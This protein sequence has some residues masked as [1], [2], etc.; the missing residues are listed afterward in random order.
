[1][2]SIA[3]IA[4]IAKQNFYSTF[5]DIFLDDLLLVFIVKLLPLLPILQSVELRESPL[6]NATDL[7]FPHALMEC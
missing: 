6:L 2:Q 4:N 7:N 5:N 3:N 1:M